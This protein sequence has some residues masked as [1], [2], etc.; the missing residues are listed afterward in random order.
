[1]DGAVSGVCKPSIQEEEREVG[2]GGGDHDLQL[3]RR[4]PIRFNVERDAI[5]SC[6]RRES[7]LL[8]DRGGR[9]GGW[10]GAERRG[11]DECDDR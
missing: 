7:R 2:E 9:G 11:K 8:A 1:M 5:A 6:D 4:R 10:F 3:Y